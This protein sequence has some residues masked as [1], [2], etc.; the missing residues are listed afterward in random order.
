MSAALGEIGGV[1]TATPE[2]PQIPAGDHGDRQCDDRL[3]HV[4]GHL[5]QTER[6]QD[7]GHR[8]R[9]REGGCHQYDFAQPPGSG[10]QRQQEQNMI[11]TEQQVLG[12]EPEELPEALRPALADGEGVVFGVQAALPERPSTS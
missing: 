8:V 10:N 9:H 11:D 2:P 6:G 3:H 4:P 1:L 7:E 5:D 12:A